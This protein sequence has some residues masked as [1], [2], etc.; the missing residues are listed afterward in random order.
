MSQWRTVEQ[1]R[2][3]RAL[4]CVQKIKPKSKEASDYQ[5]LAKHA[6]AHIQINGLGQTLAFWRS[7]RKDKNGNLKPEGLIYEDVSAWVCERMGVNWKHT[8]NSRDEHLLVYLTKCS[9]ADYRRATVETMAFLNWLKRFAEAELEGDEH[10]P[11]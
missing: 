5:S 3:K 10:E 9:T 8:P 7:K 1:D 6:P 4:A 2:A 11:T